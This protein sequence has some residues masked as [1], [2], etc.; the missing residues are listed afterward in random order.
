[1]KEASFYRK[2]NGHIR[3]ILCP[4]NC[5]I[6]EG[7]R[8]ICRVRKNENGKLFSES[9]GQICSMNFDPIEKKPLYHFFPGSI[10]FSAGS[11]GCNLHCKFCQN[12]EISQ[13]GIEEFGNQRTAAPEEL[14]N[15]ALSR[16]NNIGI[17]YTYNE[18]TVWIEFMLETAKLAQKEGL[19][20]VMVTNGFIN[21]EPLE[22]LF[23]FMD[24]FS[25]DLKAFTEEFYKTITASRLEPV[26]NA[27]KM[28][29]KSGRHLEITNLVITDT[30]DDEKEF[31][32]MVDWIATELGRE[33]VLHISRYFPMFKM[34]KEATSHSKLKT[35]FEIADE[36]LDYVYLGNLR[37]GEG[38]NTLCPGCKTEV[39]ERIGYDTRIIGLDGEGRCRNCKQQVITN[40]LLVND[41]H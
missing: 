28:I 34:D 16:D 7:K 37:S 39:I 2:E 31:T 13:T 33:I 30:N 3:C 32:K 27:L 5:I 21:P 20:N 8:G 41:S 11:L 17:A 36:K 23:P 35:L 6:H 15:N 4:H 19:K 18:P 22:E 9:Y 10:I 40:E 1:V 14:I 38:Q 26:L 24:A 25:V 12:W 29:R